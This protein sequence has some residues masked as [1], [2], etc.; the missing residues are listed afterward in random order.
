MPALPTPCMMYLRKTNKE[1][2]KRNGDEDGAGHLIAIVDTLPV[3]TSTK[4]LPRK[5]LEIKRN[6]ALLVTKFGQT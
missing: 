5:P 4:A 6:S 2:E 1:Q 3:S